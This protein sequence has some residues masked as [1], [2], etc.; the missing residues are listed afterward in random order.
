LGGTAVL[1]ESL[2]LSV[3]IVSWNVKEYL[4]KC[5][6]SVNNNV[7]NLSYEIIVIDNNSSDGTAE[8]IR[9]EF[10]EIK[11]TINR[12]NVGFARANN[13]AFAQCN[14]R[15]ILLI[16]PDTYL[17]DNSINRLIE[18]LESH[19]EVGVVGPRLLNP[20]KSIQYICFDFPS[21]FSELLNSLN[22]DNLVRKKLF[23]SKLAGLMERGIPFEVDW[24]SG[25]CLILRSQILNEIGDLDE[26]YFLFS[27]EMEW[28]FRIKARGWKVFLMGNVFVIHYGSRSTKQNIH[29]MLIQRQKSRHIFFKNYR[30]HAFQLG[31]RFIYIFS[32]MLKILIK[33]F[34]IPLAVLLPR[35]SAFINNIGTKD[36]ISVRLKAYFEL[37]LLY[38]KPSLSDSD[39]DHYLYT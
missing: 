28:C 18:F 22:L 9:Q 4:V 8:M 10:P 5:L 36:E 1:T 11:L 34:S 6:S 29:Q 19:K 31:I 17:I 15:Y 37:L 24:V 27:E 26:K 21:L 14:G 33:I 32:F 20:N 3:V 25:A 38:L 16:N 2:D 7:K 39:F 30:G 12:E 23:K 13:Q 35:D